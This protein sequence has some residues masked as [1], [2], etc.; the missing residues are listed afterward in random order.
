[1]EWV[2]LSDNHND[3]IKKIFQT[4]QNKFAF[5]IQFVDSNFEINEFLKKPNTRAL[6]YSSKVCN[7]NGIDATS[8]V[9]YIGALSVSEKT[10]TNVIHFSDV[11]DI[12]I[13]GILPAIRDNNDPCV[14][15]ITTY[16]ISALGSQ[17]ASPYPVDIG[18]MSLFR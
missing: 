16:I 10:P 7:F 11:D 8:L 9:I 17:C 2:I 3:H 1:M 12:M 13:Y 6:V 4:K 14:D 5:K 18:Q 15:D